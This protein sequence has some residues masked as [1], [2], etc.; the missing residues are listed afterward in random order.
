MKLE[1]EI[2]YDYVVELKLLFFKEE[3]ECIF[4]LVVEENWNYL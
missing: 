1:K 4:L 2:I 3:L